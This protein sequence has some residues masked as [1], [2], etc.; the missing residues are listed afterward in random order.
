M[1][2]YLHGY[3]PAATAVCSVDTLVPC[4]SFRDVQCSSASRPFSVLPIRT[5]T[6]LFK[7]YEIE[8]I[9]STE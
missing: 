6:F 3:S 2:E 5:K 7:D 8:R 4:Y 1:E 9:A